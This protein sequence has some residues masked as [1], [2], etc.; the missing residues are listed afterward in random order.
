M[1]GNER[2]TISGMLVIVIATGVLSPAIQDAEA[3][4]PVPHNTYGQ[5]KDSGGVEFTNGSFV[6]SWIDGVMYGWSWTFYDGGNPDPANRSGRFDIDTA[7]NHITIP[8]DPDTPWVK[9]GGDQ[10][11]DDIMY[12]W[13]DMTEIT[14]TLGLPTPIFEQTT[15]W[16][17]FVAEHVNL[18]IAPTQPP[19]LPKINNIVTQPS[20]GMATQYIYIY[21]PEGTP[22]DE[23]YLEKND[24]QLHNAATRMNLTGTISETLYFY[25]DLGATDYL[26]VDGDE[27]K[28][29]WENPG[30]PGTPF[31]GMD[32]VVDRV[33]FNATVG[34]THYGEPDNTIMPDAV[35][36]I[37]GNEIRRQPTAGS[38]TND[39]SVDFLPHMVTG[40]PPNPPYPL[41]VETGGQASGPGQTIDHMTNRIDPFLEFTHGD[42]DADPQVGYRI[43]VAEDPDFTSLI[44]SSYQ[45]LSNEDGEFYGGPPLSPGT[46]FYY[47]ARTKDVHDYGP[48]ANTTMCMNTPPPVPALLWPHNVT[49]APL[50]VVLYWMIVVDAEGDPVHYE[51]EVDDDLFF[52]SPEFLLFTSS[53]NSGPENYM[54]MMRYYWRVRAHDGWEYSPWAYEFGPWFFDTNEGWPPEA[55]HLAVEGFYNGTPEMQHVVNRVNPTLNWTYSSFGAMGS[56]QAYQTEVGTLPGQGN[57][58]IW[59]D[60][61]GSVEQVAYNGTELDECVDYHFRVRVQDDTPLSLWSQWEEIMFHTNCIPT[62]PSPISPF[63]GTV[64][65]PYSELSFTWLTSTDADLLDTVSYTIQVA[66]DPGFTLIILEWSSIPGPGI[67][68]FEPAPG[69]CYYWRINATDGWESSPWS[70]VMSFCADDFPAPPVGLAV[71][72]YMSGPELMHITVPEPTLNW[73]FIDPDP[74]DIQTEFEVEVW[75]GPGATGTLVWRYAEVTSDGNADYNVDG[76]ATPLIQGNSYHFRVRTKDALVWSDWSELQFEM[77]AMPPAPLLISPA[78]GAQDV[79]VTLDISWQPVTDLNGDSILYRWYVDTQPIPTA[80]YVDNGTTTETSVSLTVTL[81]YES[82][83]YWIVCSDDGWEQPHCSE[84]WSFRTAP[85]PNDPPNLPLGLAVDELTVPPEILHVLNHEPVLNWTFSDP[86]G[87]TQGAY[88]VQ[89]WEEFPGTG[90]LV[91]DS[92]TTSPENA[93][94]YDGST[95]EDGQDYWFRVKTSDERGLW[96][97]WSELMFHMNAKPPIPQPLSPANGSANVVPGTV[98]LQ[99]TLVTDSE[100]DSITYP[101]H[102]STSYD[103]L[104]VISSGWTI[105]TY[106]NITAGPFKTLYWQVWADD[107]YE[108]SGYG[109]VFEFT[110]GADAGS[111]SGVVIDD[112]SEE[113]LGGVV[114]QLLDSEGGIVETQMTHDNGGFTFHDLAFGTYSV[115]V[116]KP[117]YEDELRENIVVT[118]LDAD[119]DLETIRLKPLPAVAFDWTLIL[120]ALV[121]ILIVT[122][123]LLLFL[124]RR[125]RRGE[126]SEIQE[127]S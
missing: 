52:A 5:A 74:G 110:T 127:E 89:V 124:K 41:T 11:V 97:D 36:P 87:D 120:A 79:P 109:P 125:R 2:V 118:F 116:T 22:M 32:V 60:S 48:W 114:A 96:S 1:R 33:E 57:G 63:D 46:C 15:V 39:C 19:A 88:H 65:A 73:T 81:D 86:D 126:D 30:G 38:D 44:W 55:T 8:G 31:S 75:T 26:D 10:D 82:D 56:Q 77:S 29:V 40:R 13:G 101:L 16:R 49:V 50:E 59:A 3:A 100:G 84:A 70:G 47:R 6:S 24:G 66:L 43:E 21:G 90:N 61:G 17:T 62:T 83:Y 107:G 119:Q 93:V 92:N 80:L 27:L 71:G 14:L 115:R 91:W 23:F 28:L 58:T 9:E 42:A 95:L 54:L 105:Y 112:S 94:T 106:K 68:G 103:F 104:H 123:I 78:N 18:S 37:F 69:E 67:D 108:S 76:T 35:A 34:G 12:A 98:Q 85:P 99:W 53:N 102:V 64:V 20:D 117:G 25:V 113:P 72:S 4:I 122:A 121:V 7:G 51:V 111:V 45:P